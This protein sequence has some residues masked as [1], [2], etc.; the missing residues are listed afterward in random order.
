MVTVDLRSLP[1]GYH[2]T[3]Q[4]KQGESMLVKWIQV[5]QDEGTGKIKVQ[6]TEIVDT[7]NNNMTKTQY[8]LKNRQIFHN[9]GQKE[10]G[11]KRE[12]GQGA[13]RQ[14]KGKAVKTRRKIY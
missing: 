9:G 7:E 11:R 5:E 3:T 13:T 14:D 2:H 12:N 6:G 1:C 10:E 8:Y 4:K